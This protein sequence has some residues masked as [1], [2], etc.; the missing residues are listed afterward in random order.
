MLRIKFILYNLHNKYND[1]FRSV[2]SSVWRIVSIALKVWQVQKYACNANT[3]GKR[4]YMLVDI[5]VN[6]CQAIQ[7]TTFKYSTQLNET[8]NYSFTEWASFLN[9]LFVRRCGNESKPKILKLQLFSRIHYSSL[10]SMV[11]CWNRPLHNTDEAIW[12]YYLLVRIQNRTEN[13]IK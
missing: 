7:I 2:Y 4:R 5:L 11:T 3:K 13:L 8:E 6:G 1:V 9:V 12:L 10:H